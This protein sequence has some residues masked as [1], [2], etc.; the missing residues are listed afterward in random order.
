MCWLPLSLRRSA[1]FTS[2]LFARGEGA[3]FVTKDET[4][5]LRESTNWPVFTRIG[6]VAWS[7]FFS[8]N[9]ESSSFLDS[10]GWVSACL[11]RATC[12]RLSRRFDCLDA[13]LS[14][15]KLPL[16]K[17]VPFAAAVASALCSNLERN[18]LTTLRYRSSYTSAARRCLSS[19]WIGSSRGSSDSGSRKNP[20]LR[21]AATNWS[22]RGVCTIS[23][24]ASRRERA[25]KPAN[26]AAV[27]SPRVRGR[28]LLNPFKE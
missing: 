12:V 17:E 19:S 1:S 23:R 26:P 16:S 7:T 21:T 10:W 28:S 24:S 22:K 20:L 6:V 15:S 14:A 11:E 27:I 5:T 25:P 8:S 9:F 18:L 2:N 3:S 4:I 13:A